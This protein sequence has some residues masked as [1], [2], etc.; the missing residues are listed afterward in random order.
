M[1]RLNPSSSSPLL[2]T[3]YRVI[4]PSQHLPHHRVAADRGLVAAFC[5]LVWAIALVGAVA[6]LGAGAVHLLQQGG[7]SDAR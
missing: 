5:G 2:V 3:G 4:E 1:K 7:I 6:Y